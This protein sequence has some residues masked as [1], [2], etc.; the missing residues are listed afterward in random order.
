M[1][2]NLV[3]RLGQLATVGNG[4]SLTLTRTN[5]AQ[6]LFTGARSRFEFTLGT[7]GSPTRL[8]ARSA[9]A[10]AIVYR[11]ADPWRP[12]TTE[13]D[14]YAG[15]YQS[16][17]LDVEYGF[18]IGERGLTLWNRKLGAIPLVPTYHDGFYGGGLYLAFTRD[19]RDS[20]DGLTVSTPRARKI[21]FDRH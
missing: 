7:D 1:P 13:L 15:T 5:S 12:R 16:A 19:D 21:R 8:E 20:I 2:L 6:L 11:R 18:R 3:V 9:G 14:T 4:P 10:S 17:E